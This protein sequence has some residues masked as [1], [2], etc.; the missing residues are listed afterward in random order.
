MF[1]VLSMQPF[2]VC[3]FKKCEYGVQN[4]KELR[5]TFQ[6]IT[7]SISTSPYPFI[8]YQHFMTEKIL[9]EYS[10]VCIFMYVCVFSS[11]SSDNFIWITV[12]NQFLWYVLFPKWSLQSHVLHSKEVN[13]LHYTVSGNVTAVC[14]WLYKYGLLN[15]GKNTVR[16]RNYVAWLT[17]NA[18]E[19]SECWSISW[20]LVDHAFVGCLWHRN[21]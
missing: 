8:C 10:D 14:R 16:I 18:A 19:Q 7:S 13:K 3:V 4:P 12:Y 17:S 11:S 6:L 9:K 2:L 20:V 21:R 5:K 15:T 1:A